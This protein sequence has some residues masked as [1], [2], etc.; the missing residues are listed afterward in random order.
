[1]Q[2]EPIPFRLFLEPKYFSD[3]RDWGSNLIFVI[4]EFILGLKGG[5]S[6][7]GLVGDAHCDLFSF[8]N[9]MCTVAA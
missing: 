3:S 8:V 1:M 4:K 5:L 9:R 2:P 7:E 6:E